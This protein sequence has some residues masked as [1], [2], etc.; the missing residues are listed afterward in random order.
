MRDKTMTN[1]FIKREIIIKCYSD[2]K[3]KFFGG[4]WNYHEGNIWSILIHKYSKSM[5]FIKEYIF[6]QNKES[7]MH[8]RYNIHEANILIYRFEKI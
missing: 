4:K 8:N 2:Y 5:I 1:K 6:F 7:L 3:D